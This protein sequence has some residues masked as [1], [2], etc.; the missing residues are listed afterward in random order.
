[1]NTPISKEEIA[2]AKRKGIRGVISISHF[3]NRRMRRAMLK[4]PKTNNRKITKARK[5]LK[6]FLLKLKG[7][8]FKK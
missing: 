8:L 5:P 2:Q 6:H 1:M 4:A 3:P 7:L